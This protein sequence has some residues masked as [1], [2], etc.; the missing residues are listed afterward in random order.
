MNTI[1]VR[2]KIIHTSYSI[3]I[4][5]SLFDFSNWLHQFKFSQLVII[6]DNNI[7]KLYGLDLKHKLQM[8]G[9]SV[10]LCSFIA[11]EKSKNYQTK[12]SIEEE[13]L[14]KHCDKDTLIL[15][16]GGGVVGDIAGFIAATFLR[17]IDYIHLPTSLLAMV[18]S[19][20][21]GKT[22]INN[23]YGKNLIGSI[24]Q[25]LLV[26]TDISLLKT[27][28][29]K[30]LINGLFECIKIFLTHD[31]ENFHYV[32]THLDQIIE[33]NENIL[34][35]L[36]INAIRIKANVVEKDEKDH[37]I[38]QTLNFGHT[39]GHALEKLSNYYLLHGYAV[40]YGI[41]VEATISYLLG[42]LDSEQLMIIKKLMGQLNIHGL[43]LKKYDVSQLIQ[44][45][46]FDKKM[47]FKKVNYI[48]LKKIG[49]V[50]I[51]QQ[52]FVH[53]V[54]DDIVKRALIK[55]IEE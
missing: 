9:Y 5:K 11:G 25:P 17:G 12:H 19:S 51:S 20:I 52:Q 21:G 44:A 2:P 35:E 7:K 39:M 48:L 24:Y 38:R 34:N 27:L 8:A 45:T 23:A 41:L 40:A 22:G 50:S 6:T 28:T 33:G 31:K 46:K 36:L 14:K 55:I 3:L 37:A 1:V 47:R 54:P 43:H 16:L 13:M 29:K 26:I 30:H 32:E 49:Q 15:A 10:F 53:A 42:L 4:G 18:D